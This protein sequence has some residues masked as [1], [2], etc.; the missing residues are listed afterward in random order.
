MK[1]LSIMLMA[2]L[3]LGFT[4][5]DDYVEPNPA[6]QTNPQETIVSAENLVVAAGATVETGAVDLDTLNTA[7]EDAAVLNLVS[8]E[9]LPENEAI[10]E[11]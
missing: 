1:K 2:A 3:G 10:D 6:P 4:A 11:R 8:F 5:C 7:K 9:G